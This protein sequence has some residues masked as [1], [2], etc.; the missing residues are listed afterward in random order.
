MRVILIGVAATL[1]LEA[2][3][4]WEHRRY[5]LCL[6]L[7]HCGFICDSVSSLCPLCNTTWVAWG[8]AQPSPFPDSSGPQST[9]ARSAV[10]GRGRRGSP[11]GPSPSERAA[12]KAPR[13]RWQFSWIGACAQV[14]SGPG[15]THPEL[16][17]ASDERSAL[18]VFPANA[19]TSIPLHHFRLYGSK[20]ARQ[21][22]E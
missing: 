7:D 5:T 1:L 11:T 6:K 18:S 9:T 13:V 2:K 14:L 19:N 10:K 20:P 8:P 4:W 21:G 22:G 15:Q 17:K 3:L 16:S 12:S